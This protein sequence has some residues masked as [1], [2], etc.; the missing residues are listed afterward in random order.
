MLTRF[1]AFWNRLRALGHR[2]AL[3]AELAEEMRIHRAMLER[4][5]VAAGLAAGDARF[6]AQRQFGNTTQLAE[7][8]REMWSF[9]SIETW[10]QDIR[11]AVRFL[12]RSPGF[13]LVAVLS[14][15]L[16]IGAN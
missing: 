5:R 7:E 8:S 2:D 6:A 16:G 9:G 4:D 3:D 10:L 11:Y 12:R 1:V 14:L 15:A 13:T